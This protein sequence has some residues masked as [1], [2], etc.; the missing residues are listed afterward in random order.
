[1]K[2]PTS[3]VTTLKELQTSGALP[4]RVLLRDTQ[5]ATTIEI[6]L[7]QLDRLSLEASLLRVTPEKVPAETL[8]ERATLLAQRV[9]GLMEKLTVLEVDEARGE[10]LLRS[11]VPAA[12][13]TQRRYYELLLQRNGTATP[14]RYEGSTLQ[15]ARK[16]IPFSI[17]REAMAKLISDLTHGSVVAAP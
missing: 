11:D 15:S 7:L 16:A 4:Q 2:S 14:H 17:T 13:D 9:T 10:A 5:L 6:E 8:R 1:M 3:L 12:Q